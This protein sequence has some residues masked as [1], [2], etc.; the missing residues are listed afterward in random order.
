MK[1]LTVARKHT[2]SHN[3][4]DNVTSNAKTIPYNPWIEKLDMKIGFLMT[5]AV[6]RRIVEVVWLCITS[7]ISY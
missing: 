2:T 4:Y 6:C 3:A 1:C 5:S 7:N